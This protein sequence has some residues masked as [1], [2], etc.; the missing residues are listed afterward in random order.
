M[1]KGEKKNKVRISNSSINC[2]G[3]RVITSGI[4]YS[5]YERNPILLWMHRR[6][7]VSNVIGTVINL[8]VEG[9]DLVGE[10][11]FDGIG[12]NSKIAKEKWEAGTL[13]MVSANLDII[14][15]SDAPEHVIPGQTAFTATRSKLIEISVVDIGGND[16]A[17]V[18]LQYEGK[19]IALSNNDEGKQL[20]L[21]QLS[22]DKAETKIKTDFKMKNVALKLGLAET[23]TEQEVLKAIEDAQ[24]HEPKVKKLETELEAVELANLTSMVEGAITARKI[25]ADKKEH[26][27]QLG[28]K[29]GA[30][31]LKLTFDSMSATM[32]PMDVTGANATLGKPANDEWKK[33]SE[34]P[35]DK[36]M[37]LRKDDKETYMKLYKAE[38]G[39]ECDLK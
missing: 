7:D 16:D 35:A 15:L 9:D 38:Y 27:V 30:E 19:S 11:V 32:K 20:P 34:V 28:Q 18:M 2:Y 12:E 8:A 13:K 6:G 37:E 23:A 33:L 4:D 22:S 31:T 5:Q 29:V 14:E 21:L 36:I 26:F 25:G 3:S 17:L 39:I 24:A 10:L 1:N